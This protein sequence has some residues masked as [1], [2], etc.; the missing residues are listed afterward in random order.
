MESNYK[1]V[2]FFGQVAVLA[3]QGS[4]VRAWLCGAK[5]AETAVSA[6]HSAAAVQIAGISRG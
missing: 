2:A 4:A 5:H 6:E 1:C 3:A